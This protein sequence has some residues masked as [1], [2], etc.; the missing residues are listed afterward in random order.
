L[1]VAVVTVLGACATGEL[2]EGG[3]SLFTSAAN[4]QTN[5]GMDPDDELGEG[6]ATGGDG[7]GDSSSGDG[8]PT[9]GGAECGNGVREPGEEC[10]GE[11]FNGLACADFGFDDGIL[12]CA[13][14]CTLF[15]NACSTCGDGQ[16]AATEVCDGNN[17]GG[18]T[19]EGL[20]YAG[21]SLMCA[22]DCSA[23][24]TSGCTQAM[25][26]GNGVIDG[27]EECDGGNLNGKTCQSLGF[28]GGSLACTQGCKLDTNGCT[29]AE[30][31]P[32]FAECNPF[33]SDCCAGLSCIL[34]L[35]CIPE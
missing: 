9:T 14:D 2:D 32:L 10:D 26:C 19:C 13:A 23:L 33:L 29:V 35:G 4:G 1:L 3:T 25:A 28:N 6:D 11:D 31:K 21:G 15:T 5:T 7:D 18:Q 30:C 22:A 20:G 16:V 17:F 12:V 34:L 8:D 24:I 27:N